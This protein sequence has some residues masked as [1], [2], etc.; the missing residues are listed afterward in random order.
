MFWKIVGRVYAIATSCLVTVWLVERWA[1]QRD[2]SFWAIL[3]PIYLPLLAL[4]VLF[5]VVGS[6]RHN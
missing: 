1:G 3:A 4:A 6:S 2:T 5:L